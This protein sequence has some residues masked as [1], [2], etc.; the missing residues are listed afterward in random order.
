MDEVVERFNAMPEGFRRGLTTGDGFD[1]FVQ[2]GEDDEDALFGNDDEDLTLDR[3]TALALELGLRGNDIDFNRPINVEIPAA[4]VEAAAL[5]DTV[6]VAQARTLVDWVGGSRIITRDG[7]LRR[8]DVDDLLPQLGIPDSDWPAADPMW[9]S[10]RWSCLGW[11][12]PA[13]SCDVVVGA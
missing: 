4:E 6:M 7:G 12:P 3:W 5:R 1:D 8:Q 13:G 9:E 10:T 11:P 2:A